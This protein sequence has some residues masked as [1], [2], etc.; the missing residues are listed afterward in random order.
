[1]AK[2]MLSICFQRSYFTQSNLNVPVEQNVTTRDDTFINRYTI[3]VSIQSFFNLFIG[4]YLIYLIFSHYGSL[5]DVCTVIEGSPFQAVSQHVL[6][7]RNCVQVAMVPDK[8]REHNNKEC[9][10]VLDKVMWRPSWP[11]S[12]IGHSGKCW[13]L[14]TRLGA[15]STNKTCFC[16]ESQSPEIEPFMYCIRCI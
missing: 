7:L 14:T 12:V 2:Q 15:G 10:G 11:C 9:V 5:I 13:L 1:M 8:H 3:Y 4:S 6:F 16:R